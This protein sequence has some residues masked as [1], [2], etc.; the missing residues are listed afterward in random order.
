MSTQNSESVHRGG[1]GYRPDVD[2]L[3][4]VAVLLVVTFHAFPSLAPGGF[5]GVDVFFVI[6]GFLISS[7]ILGALQR[8]SFSFLTF[9]ARRIR[10]IFPALTT[11]VFAFIV[12][13]W[14]ASTP[15]EYAEFGQHTVAGSLFVSNLLLWAQAGYFDI[16]AASKPLLH[17]WSLGIEEQFYIVWPLFLFG[18]Q[19]RPLAIAAIW[20]ISLAS[21]LLMTSTHP[22]A[23]FYSPLS[24]AWEL[25]SGALLAQLGVQSEEGGAF[26]SG[27]GRGLRTLSVRGADALSIL[28]LVLIVG[29]AG[30]LD[31][32]TSFPGWWA[33]VPVSGALALIAAGPGALVNRL[34][35]SRR[36]MVAVGLIS[37]PL[38]LW[39]W[40]ILVFLR[41]SDFDLMPATSRVVR[42][43]ALIVAFSLAYLTYRFI[44]LEARKA[45][46]ATAVLCVL[47]ATILGTG[48]AISLTGGFEGRLGPA[49][50]GVIEYAESNRLS[51]N[52]DWRV[53]TC[54]LNREQDERF[55]RSECEGQPTNRDST[56][57]LWGDSHA[58][59]LYRGLAFSLKG[60]G[61]SIVQLTASV[62][63]PLLQY[64]PKG[65]PNCARINEYVLAWIQKK[66]PRTVIVAA[67]WLRY[68][69]YAQIEATIRKA[70]SAGVQTVLVVGPLPVFP[71]S[72]PTLIIRQSH[73]GQIP[74]RIPNLAL[75]KLKDI[76]RILR[77]VSKV[78][79][80]EFVSPLDRLCD[81][82]GCLV[83]PGGQPNLL[84]A[85]D[86]GHL[87][88]AGSNLIV[89]DLICGQ[90]SACSPGNPNGTRD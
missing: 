48:A 89:H 18:L 70:H 37:Y 85:F 26:L 76:D 31:A 12:L 56:V 47:M 51:V 52:V 64:D 61:L 29:A 44:E 42:L 81:E 84:L 33:L 27:L 22:A 66:R 63:P 74:E 71:R 68:P 7:I 34:V 13:G 9:Y 10:R 32:V 90:T 87:T 62:C 69:A 36:G 54:F 39:H 30:G 25:L 88:D 55:F 53:G 46:H 58:A 65:E 2:G 67:N 41:E 83:A 82:A 49:Q 35:L 50:R 5:I 24:R 75:P 73:G 57:L 3:R 21:S 59:H 1:L 16:E 40:P 60:R 4:A 14:F 19:K 20:A 45:R 28:G 43:G 23:A 15:A 80:A 78:T 11:M 38:Y 17:L 86:Y 8:G 79:G 72:Q 6:S 77:Q